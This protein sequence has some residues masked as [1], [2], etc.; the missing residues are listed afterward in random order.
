VDVAVVARGQPFTGAGGERKAN[1]FDTEG[2]A[3]RARKP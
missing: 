2:V 1:K 3:I